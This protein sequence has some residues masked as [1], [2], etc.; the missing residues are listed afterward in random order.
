VRIALATTAGAIHS[1]AIPAALAVLVIVRQ[2][3]C[4]RALES[5]YLARAPRGRHSRRNVPREGP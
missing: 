5:R 3:A 4:S 2:L 1:F